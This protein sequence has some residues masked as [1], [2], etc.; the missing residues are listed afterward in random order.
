L[1]KDRSILFYEVVPS[2]ALFFYPVGGKFLLEENLELVEREC[3]FMGGGKQCE[4]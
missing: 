3:P 1:T 2:S 4:G